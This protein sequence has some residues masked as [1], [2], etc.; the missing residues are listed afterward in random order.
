MP[1]PALSPR[2]EL[3]FLLRMAHAKAARAFGSAL[4]PVALEGRHFGLLLTLAKLGPV[5]QSRLITELRSDK[6]AIVRSVD[7]LERQGLVTRTPVPGDRRARTVALTESG[8]QRLA[9]GRNLAEETA[10]RLFASLDDADV[11]TLDRLLRRIL[12]SPES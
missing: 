3:G 12:D 4:A 2:A 7:D 6:S 1:P 5:I 8:R 9:D 11:A 10:G